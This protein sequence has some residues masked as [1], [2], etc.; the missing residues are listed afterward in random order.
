MN[1]HTEWDAQL[2]DRAEAFVAGLLSE[3]SEEAFRQHLAACE[4]CRARVADLE[5][6]LEGLALAVPAAEPGPRVWEAITAAAAPS[7]QTWRSWEVDDPSSGPLG[8]FLRRDDPG[9]WQPTGVAGVEARQ[10]FCDRD[11]DRVTMLVRMAPG[12][13]YPAHVHGGPEECYVLEGDLLVG[14]ALLMS[15]GDYQRAETGSTHPVQSTEGG[16]LLLLHSSLRDE[17]VA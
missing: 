12:A 17:L 5:A 6:V 4:L 7:V 1:V 11:A 13:S 3:T 2:Q 16:C 8:L 15:A 10:L 14:D 9:D